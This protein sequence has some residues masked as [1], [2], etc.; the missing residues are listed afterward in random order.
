MAKIYDQKG[1]PERP[2]GHSD[3]IPFSLEP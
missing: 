2:F 3:C 1:H